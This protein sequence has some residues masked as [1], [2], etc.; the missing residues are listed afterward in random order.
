MENEN[1]KDLWAAIKSMGN[2]SDSSYDKNIERDMK[3]ELGLRKNESL[4]KLQ[5]EMVFNAFFR[6]ISPL[7]AMYEDILCLFEDCGANKTSENVE[8]EFQS[9]K[10]SSVRFNIKHFIEA[11]SKFEDVKTC[12]KKISVNERKIQKIWSLRPEESYCKK[13]EIRNALFR[14]WEDEYWDKPG[15]WPE[16]SLNFE[17]AAK[18]LPISGLLLK[19]F[20]CWQALYDFYRS[21]DRINWRDHIGQYS[22]Q[23]RALLICE[24]DHCLFS[25]LFSLYYYA[26]RYLDF[27]KEKKEEVKDKLTGFLEIFHI[28]DQYVEK[29]MQVWREFLSLPVWKKR[30]EV[31]SIWI[32]TQIAAAFPKECVTFRIKDGKLIFPFLGACLATVKLDDT[33]FD[34]WTELRTQTIVAPVGKG[35]KKGIQPDYSI[36]CGDEKNIQDTVVV[37]ECKQYKRAN[38]KNFSEAIMDYAFNRPKAKVLLADYGEINL[39]RITAAI[40]GIPGERYEVFSRCRPQN[41]SAVSFLGTIRGSLCRYAD[42]F[43]VDPNFSMELVLV[44]NGTL[45]TQDYDLHMNFINDG[46]LRRVSYQAQNIDGVEYSGDT[47]KSPGEER[48]H[49]KKWNQGV[50]DVWVNN[51]SEECDFW[52]GCPIVSVKTGRGQ[53]MEIEPQKSDPGE[54]NWWHVL[55]IDTRMNIGYI[56]NK[57]ET[58]LRY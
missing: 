3:S 17:K 53:I 50:Y 40:K 57:M 15:Q 27:S 18:D 38:I 9:S 42:F 1:T 22:K 46:T 32:F 47:R 24:T 39:E 14:K 6:V 26:E 28:E 36:V 34:I 29:N 7:S 45:E 43:K 37:V 41:E 54:G 49:I 35:R 13:E 19:S 2:F 51:Y 44:W 5:P 4:Q 20:E 21:T 55:K 8:I 11:K 10:T 16:V 12:I 33:E 23:Q 56:I 31:Y 52:N 25:V 30:H 58:V 48:I